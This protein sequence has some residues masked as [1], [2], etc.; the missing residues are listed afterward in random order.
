MDLIYADESLVE[1][2]VLHKFNVDFDTTDKKD[3][4]ISVGI[5]NN[6]LQGG[7]YWY[8]EGTEY[9]G[10]I[11]KVNV[12]S[13]TNEIQYTGRNFRG[14]LGSKVIKPPT[15]AD[16]MILSGTMAEVVSQ[17][18]SDAGLQNLFVVDACDITVTNHKFNRYVTVYDGILALCVRYNTIPAFTIK[19]GRIHVSFATPTDYSNENE[20]T[21]KDFQFSITKTYANVNHLICLGQGDLKDRTV[22]HLYADADGNISETQTLF[23]LDEIE[24]TYENTNAA[25][26]EELKQLGVEK[27]AELKNQDGFEVT[28]SDTTLKIGDIIGGYETTTKTY[29]AREIVN[30][31][32][33]IDD[34]KIDLEYKVGVDDAKSSTSSESSSGGGTGAKGADGADAY[35]VAV[36]NGFEGTEEEW[37]ASLKGEQGEQGIPGEK[38]DPGDDAEFAGYTPNDFATSSHT[39]RYLP[40]EGGTVTGTLILSKTTDASG[41]TATQP[42]L[43]VG[44][45]PT[46]A[47]IQMDANEIMAKSN[48]TTPSALYL[49]PD[50][51]LVTVGTGGLKVNGN[52]TITGN[53]YPASVRLGN[54]KFYFGALTD[55][56]EYA[57]LGINNNNYCFVGNNSLEQLQLRGTTCLLKNASGTTVTSDERLKNSFKTLDEFDEVFMDL[58]PVAFKYNN[59]T[60]DR[61]HFGFGA[62]SVKECLEKHGFTTKD[63]AGYVEALPDDES[64]DVIKGLIYS[65]FTA[66]NTHMIQQIKTTYDEKI[67]QLETR[68]ADLEKRLGE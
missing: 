33:K 61:F 43:I 53:L 27:F 56:T 46:T 24:L 19:D 55:G 3:F 54:D 31:I 40:L 28:T 52:T 30:I 22:C 11:D 34:V 18:I 41:K 6:V 45:T 68:I 8:I 36:R 49:N 64:M 20:Y 50:G 7:W 58:E 29:V 57:I 60:S 1:Q 65:E 51:G 38:G 37:I 21:Q 10:R 62:N 48:G 35:Q 67:E 44:G 12:I 63:F 25:T 47:H 32:A 2:G 14:I 16:Y 66:W 39:H 9:G 17:L 15:G 5:K 13:E 23:G 42:A 4:L 26:L 59:G